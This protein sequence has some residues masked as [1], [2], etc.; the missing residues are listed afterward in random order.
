MQLYIPG[1]FLLPYTLRLFTHKYLLATMSQNYNKKSPT[2][3]RIRKLPGQNTPHVT[4]LANLPSSRSCRVSLRALPRLSCGSSRIKPHGMA[5]H[6]PR[7]SIHTVR[8]R[9]LP[10]SHC[11]PSSVSSSPAIIPLPDTQRSLRS[12]PRDMSFNLWPS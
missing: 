2:I 10:R 7:T 5:L 8:E 12:K 4:K 1:L 6:H 9:N 11:P 3:K